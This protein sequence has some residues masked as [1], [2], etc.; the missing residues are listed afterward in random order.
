MNAG[1]QRLSVIF[2]HFAGLAPEEFEKSL[3]YWQYRT[4]NKGDFYNQ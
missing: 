4:Y 3:S 2:H 1:Y